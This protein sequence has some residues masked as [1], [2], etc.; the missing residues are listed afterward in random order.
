[1][2]KRAHLASRVCNGDTPLT[3]AVV[4]DN[5]E[6]VETFMRHDPSLAYI[7]CGACNNEDE[8][9]ESNNRKHS[10]FILATCLG[11]VRIAEEIANHCPDSAFYRSGKNKLNALHQA[12]KKEERKMVEYLLRTPQF[13]RLINQADSGG[14]LPLHYAAEM[15]NTELL[16]SLLSHK[17]QDCTAFDLVCSRNSLISHKWVHN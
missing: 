14:K 10:P 13:R 11:R 8:E 1:L 6:M 12:V 2:K 16:R 17:A 3:L 4:T 7:N 9:D 15:C 5:L